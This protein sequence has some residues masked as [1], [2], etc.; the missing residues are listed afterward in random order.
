MS[1]AAP[2]AH[3]HDHPVLMAHGSVLKTGIS[4]GKI[5]TWLF[6]GSEVMFF[7]GLIGAY[8]VLR[9]GQDTW[10]D[11]ASKDFP[12]DIP[13][14]AI[15]TFFLICSSC[16]LVYAL[17][18]IQAGNRGK[19]N[20]GLLAT[21]IIGGIFVGIQAYEY[22]LLYEHGFRPDADIF[23]SCFYLMTGF[24]GAHVAMGV[25]AL[26]V[27]TVM[28]FAGKF[29]PTEFAPVELTGLYWHFVDLV[30]IILFVIVYLI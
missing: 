19:G 21:T 4:N 12:L 9:L 26:A 7:T 14:T 5:A 2:H 8:I 23:G 16:T 1:H 25:I 6:L 17:Q 3:G 29:S 22:A 11:P 20:L 10:V 28:G 15:N 24:H 18:H 13:L 30:W 27:L